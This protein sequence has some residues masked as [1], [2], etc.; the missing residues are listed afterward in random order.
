M[1]QFGRVIDQ[2]AEIADSVH[3]KLTFFLVMGL[4]ASFLLAWKVSSSES[5]IWWNSIK[6]SLV[7]MPATV[8]VFAWFVLKQLR[9][10]PK[11]VAEFMDGE[12]GVVV[13]LR[14]FKEPMGLRGLF[15]SI[16]ELRKEDSLE[17]VFD[18][19]SGIALIANPVFGVLALL[20]LAV[21]SLLIV[22]TP[23]VMLL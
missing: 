9:D 2:I 22:I 23:F 4:L 21:L 17:A 20:S 5:A 11:H 15:T 12:L 18:T 13:Q 3:A 19:I 6:C 1:E 10:A 8:W 14:D 7:L 16:Q